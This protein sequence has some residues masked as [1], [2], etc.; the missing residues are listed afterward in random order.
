MITVYGIPN[1]DSV[2][3]ARLWLAE[4]GHDYQFHDFKKQGLPEAALDTWLA[5]LGWEQVLNKQGTTW[6]KLSDAVKAGVVDST[7]AKAFLLANS[8]C[9]KRPVI[10]WGNGRL[11]VGYTPQAWG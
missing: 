2:K 11:S 1:C 8:S 4:H 3:K 9:I 5:A 7:S 10:D 6:R